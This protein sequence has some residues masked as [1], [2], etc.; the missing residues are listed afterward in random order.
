MT[1]QNGVVV[2][3]FFCLYGTDT[4]RFEIYGESARLAVDYVARTLQIAA[5]GQ[6]KPVQRIAGVLGHEASRLKNALTTRRDPS[7]ETALAAFV[8][9][10]ASGRRQIQPDLS[11]GLRVSLVVDAAERSAATGQSQQVAAYPS[12]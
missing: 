7:Y 12:T 6:R 9:A 1:L 3:S 11:D 4:N 2:Q 10:I 5:R 8:N